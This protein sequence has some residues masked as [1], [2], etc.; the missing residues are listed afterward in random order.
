MARLARDR[1]SDG[2]EGREFCYSRL[3]PKSGEPKLL[4]LISCV[5]HYQ[6]SSEH[7]HKNMKLDLVSFESEF[8]IP[9]FVQFQPSDPEAGGRPPGKNTGLTSLTDPS[10]WN[11][12]R[13]TSARWAD[14]WINGNENA[15]SA[16]TMEEKKRMKEPSSGI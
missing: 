16:I 2:P 15:R 14:H 4:R 12:H 8:R 13:P 5:D 10:P 3:L 11:P 1:T 7:H 9:V 6:V